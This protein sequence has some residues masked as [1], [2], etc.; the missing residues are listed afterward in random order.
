MAENQIESE[1]TLLDA[2]RKMDEQALVK[3]F[4]QYSS[5]LFKYILRLCGD[6][7]MADHVVGDV[8]ARLLDQLAAGNG[9]ASNLRSYLYQTA[10]HR[11]IDEARVSRRKV[12]FE[13][14][15]WLQQNAGSNSLSLEEQVLYKLILHAIGHEL[16]ADQR[17][18]IVLR[19]LEGFSLAE[20]ALIMGKKV[21]HVKVLQNRA[22]M[23]LRKA[24]ESSRVTQAVP[25]RRRTISL[26]NALGMKLP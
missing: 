3:I 23:A 24:L 7:V 1:S 11:L 19:F 18:V 21:N 6:P 12:S 5:P 9:P 14:A 15:A 25:S 2:A 26:S 13:T 10:Y 8:F 16:S 17:H 4:D 20:T 22:I